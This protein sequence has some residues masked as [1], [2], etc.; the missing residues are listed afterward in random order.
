MGHISY[1]WNMMLHLTLMRD[2]VH[3]LSINQTSCL[4]QI[5]INGQRL[6]PQTELWF[7]LNYNRT[8]YGQIAHK[9]I[10]GLNF[11][12]TLNPGIH[13]YSNRQQT[14]L[15]CYISYIADKV[16]IITKVHEKDYYENK[17]C[18]QM[19]ENNSKCITQGTVSEHC[20]TFG[21]VCVSLS[22][23]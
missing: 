21:C 16:T 18:S 22:L 1:L 2:P 14:P 9:Q 7:S 8:H 5:R 4:F 15:H 6:N 10:G 17:T 13:V 23:L 11:I 20:E 12:L 3:K 19:T